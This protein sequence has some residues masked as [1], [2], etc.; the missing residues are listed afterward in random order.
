MGAEGTEL[1]DTQQLTDLKKL[2]EFL[3][4][5]PGKCAYTGSVPRGL[6]YLLD[7]PLLEKRNQLKEKGLLPVFY[8]TGWGWRLRKEWES[9]LQTLEKNN[10]EKEMKC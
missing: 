8:S 2:C 1:V 9:M 10:E 4:Q 3:V 7:R 5:Q 6:Q